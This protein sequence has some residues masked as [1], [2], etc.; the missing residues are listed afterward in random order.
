MPGVTPN[1][2]AAASPLSPPKVLLPA[3][4]ATVL[5]MPVE[6]TRRTVSFSSTM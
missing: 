1:V 4:P 2:A 5:M 6:S 3:M